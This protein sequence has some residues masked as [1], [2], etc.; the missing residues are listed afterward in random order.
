MEHKYIS[1]SNIND[2][3]GYIKEIKDL[4]REQPLRVLYLS[5]AH[6]AVDM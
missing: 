3:Q 2:D 5:Q 6:L 1:R 4:W